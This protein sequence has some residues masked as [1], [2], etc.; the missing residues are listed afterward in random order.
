MR[1]QLND[2]SR[3]QQIRDQL[4]ALR[5]ALQVDMG[6]KSDSEKVTG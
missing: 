5:T 6:V 2:F 4:T 3:R 1:V